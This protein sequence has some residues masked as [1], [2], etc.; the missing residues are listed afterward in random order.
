WGNPAIV[1][2]CGVPKPAGYSPD[3]VQTAEVDNVQWFQQV[4]ARA[5]RW[6]AI[7]KSANIE[8]DVPTTYAAQGGLLVELGAAIRTSI[9]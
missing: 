2:R 7:R 4:N 5:V 1:L 3:S 8:V 9:P 6:T